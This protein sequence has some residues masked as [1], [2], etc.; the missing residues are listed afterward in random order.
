[1]KTIAMAGN[2]P[3]EDNASEDK[4]S[5]NSF[6][7]NTSSNNIVSQSKSERA[8]LI[9]RGSGVEAVHCADI[10]VIDSDGEI[11]HSLGDPKA[12][13]F[14]R[15][16]IK[17]IQAL[18]LIECGMADEIGLTEKEIAITC[19]SHNGSDEHRA[20]ALSILSKAGNN[21]ELLGC[22]AHWPG[23]MRQEGKY[24]TDG[25]DKDPL[26]NNCSG[27]HS[28]FLALAKKLG[29]SAED[30]LK[31]DSRTQIAVRSALSDAMEVDLSKAPQGI[32]G[33]SAP[34]YAA[35]IY[36]LA[37][38]FL[39]IATATDG[40]MYRV[41][42]AIR[43][44]PEMVSGNKRFDLALTKA[45]PGNVINKV[46]A[47]A[48]EAIA[49]R[50]PEIAIVVKISDGGTRALYAVCVEALR[51]IGL[52]EKADMKHLDRFIKPEIKNHLG[53]ITG[54]VVADF[55]LKTH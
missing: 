55:K 4:P 41:A 34:N 29:D 5:E 40:A 2:K 10:V 17:P 36:N 24:P 16:S 18:P 1:M 23:E 31:P 35:S 9:T 20:T 53:T 46:G 3:S 12:V 51:Q 6:S 26:R 42:E 22:G 37:L 11:T 47:E 25:E 32:D 28:G 39:K 52:L 54:Q 13:T 45:Y 43:A 19:G 8:A 38:G 14:M 21:P 7:G 15:S 49:F 27:K 48:L 33:C 30:Y 50:D 44:H